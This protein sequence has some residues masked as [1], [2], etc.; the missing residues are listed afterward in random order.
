MKRIA[1]IIREETYIR[2]D[3][4]LYELSDRVFEHAFMS[5][6]VSR[7]Q[8]IMLPRIVTHSTNTFRISLTHLWKLLLKLLSASSSISFNFSPIKLNFFAKETMIDI[9]CFLRNNN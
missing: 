6:Q 1:Y 8:R 9:L 2:D 7:T 4:E 3:K 5:L